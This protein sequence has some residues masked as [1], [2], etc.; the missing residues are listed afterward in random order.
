[1][2][3]PSARGPAP[4]S[5][6]VLMEQPGPSP[7]VERL[8]AFIGTWRIQASPPGGPPWP[9]GGQVTFQWLEGGAFL[10]PRWPAGV[11]RG[12]RERF[13]QHYFRSRGVERVYQMSVADGVWRLWRDGEDFSQR[14]SGTFS[15]DG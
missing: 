9:G 3:R 12:P 8:D 13:R 4:P 6:G 2:P 15:T 1:P 7:A 14:F 5:K 10:I 11:A